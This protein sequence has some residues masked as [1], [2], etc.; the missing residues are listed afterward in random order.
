MKVKE[1]KQTIPSDKLA[2]YE[3][4]ISANPKIERKGATFPYTSVNG[5]MF[6]FL[7]KDGE[8]S[9]RL[10]ETD[11]ENFVKKFKT[12]LSV[13]YGVTMKEY[14]IV[15]E[16]LLKKTQELQIYVEKSF[17]YAKALKSKATKKK[18]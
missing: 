9:I 13:Q 7:S 17:E 5:N 3:K 6:T 4:L 18:K 2:L 14:V 8:F 12:R 1:A 15:P 10:P 11:R 16:S